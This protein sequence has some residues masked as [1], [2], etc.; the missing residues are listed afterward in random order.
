MNSLF[1]ASPYIGVLSALTA[2]AIAWLLHG[3]EK[4]KQQHVS[5]WG[6]GSLFAS[7]SPQTLPHVK[8]LKSTTPNTS[9]MSYKGY[10]L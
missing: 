2:N 4:S 8:Y 3:F 6:V 1:I 5:R 10:A 7:R 9:T